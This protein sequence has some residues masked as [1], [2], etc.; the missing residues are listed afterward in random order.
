MGTVPFSSPD[1]AKSWINQISRGHFL[2]NIVLI[3]TLAAS[4]ETLV[5]RN[6]PRGQRNNAGFGH[7]LTSGGKPNPHIYKKTEMSIK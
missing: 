4:P 5:Q 2:K 3:I 7:T 6:I 1:Q